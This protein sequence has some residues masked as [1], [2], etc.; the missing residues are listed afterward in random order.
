MTKKTKVHQPPKPHDLS[1][2]SSSII[3]AKLSEAGSFKK[4]PPA[5][6]K[7]Q[8]LKDTLT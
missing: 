6:D 2:G 4:P 1:K 8:P 7:W 5:T 3:A